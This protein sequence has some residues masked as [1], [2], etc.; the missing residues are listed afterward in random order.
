MS[1]MIR[2]RM[3]EDERTL[4]EHSASAAGLTVSEFVR[5]VALGKAIRPRMP[6]TDVKALALVRQCI[7]LLKQ[8]YAKERADPEA[9][10]SALTAAERLSKRLQRGVEE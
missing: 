8:I 2:I 3:D 1:K 9:T 5:R 6:V 10:W 4:F 7:G